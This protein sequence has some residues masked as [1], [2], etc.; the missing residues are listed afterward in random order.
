MVTID[1][2]EYI[3]KTPSENTADMLEQIN[4]YC[5]SNNVMNSK[6]ELVQIEARMSSPIYLI[7]WA[8][9]Y[10]ATVIQNLVL[11]VARAHNVQ[12]SSDAQLLN[13]ADMANVKRGQASVTT[14]NVLVQAMSTQDPN[15]DPNVNEGK[16]IITSED[17]IT[18][19][20]IVYKP[21]LHPSITLECGEDESP[22]EYGYLT[23]VAQEAGS[24][25]I[26]DGAI[27]GFDTTI[28]NLHLFQQEASIPGQ[29]Q[30]S[31]ASLRER[32]QRRQ[33]SGTSIDFCTDA[34]RALPG[35]TI[36]NI[37]YNTNV[38]AP[39][40]IG[41]DNLLLPARW[42][43]IIVQGY[44][45][46]IAETYFS[47]LTAPTVDYIKDAQG[48]PTED[49][50]LRGIPESR[51]LDT[52]V[53]TTHAQQKIPVLIIKPVQKLVYIRIYLGMAITGEV[54]QVMSNALALKLSSQLTVGQ[55]I[56]SAQVLSALADYSAYSIV[57]A[58]LSTDSESYSYQT[59]QAEDVLFR[60][61][62]A[63]IT[64]IQPGVS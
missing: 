10:L 34:L 42:A 28:A 40:Y 46:D 41:A 44:S 14:F 51:I 2:R 16:C 32:I 37:I 53:Y 23:F 30:E 63:N 22:G 47:Y 29:A 8:L 35:I 15:Y 18:Y 33:Y 9:G 5:S 39:I 45:L 64:F 19:N 61:I 7:L 49:L 48:E 54:E 1:G 59:Y 20:G 25:T 52:Q 62:P 55:S 21:A 43:M 56:T 31:I 12:E 50:D 60:L 38:S 26:S 4:T 27:Q 13:I 6:N 57:G 11:S 3:V 17:T 58:M 24:F 36:A